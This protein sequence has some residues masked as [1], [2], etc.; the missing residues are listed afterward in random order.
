MRAG[1][2]THFSEKK[3][4]VQHTIGSVFSDPTAAKYPEDDAVKS[5]SVS[6]RNVDL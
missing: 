3:N 6:E 1:Q 5:E 4:Y 2:Y